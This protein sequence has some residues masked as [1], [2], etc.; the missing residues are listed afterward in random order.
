MMVMGVAIPTLAI[1]LQSVNE[2]S[3]LDGRR[4]AR[5]RDELAEDSEGNVGQEQVYKEQIIFAKKRAGVLEQQ[6]RST[7]RKANK[8]KA[9]NILL[10]QKLASQQDSVQKVE[11]STRSR[12]SHISS[13]LQKED[14]V[15]TDLQYKLAA[16]SKEISGA[17]TELSHAHMSAEHLADILVHQHGSA[18]DIKLAVD[19]AHGN[20][21]FVRQM[22]SHAND[23]VVTLQSAL[24]YQRTAQ[25]LLKK[26]LVQE[27]DKAWR[28]EKGVAEKSNVTKELNELLESEKHYVGELTGAVERGRQ[29]SKTLLNRLQKQQGN[30][31]SSF[32]QQVEVLQS[33]VKE[34]VK[35]VQR[36]ASEEESY[37]KEQSK[38][39]ANLS[40]LEKELVRWKQ[41]VGSVSLAEVRA[42]ATRFVRE[43]LGLKEE[44]RKERGALRSDRLLAEDLRRE[45]RF[46]QELRQDRRGA[47]TTARAFR[48]S[49]SPSEHGK[50][51]LRPSAASAVGASGHE[52]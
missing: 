31:S 1:Q 9:G 34:N 25:T 42:N 48:G 35:L 10:A 43:A 12:M 41:A 45:L 50:E 51:E 15:A 20:A 23:M 32:N 52:M 17:L 22:A 29:A 46:R 13:N 21:Q 4:I 33:K 28:L 18:A 6:L 39:K 2:R 38:E 14:H 8:L 36:V 40:K 44:I 5:L 26:E 30:L 11:A 16:R 19:Q 27:T 49:S 7:L 47:G 37:R 3:E 24:Q